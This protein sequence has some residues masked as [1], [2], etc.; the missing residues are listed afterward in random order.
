MGKLLF[1]EIAKNIL[2]PIYYRIP[3]KIRLGKTYRKHRKFLLKTRSW[4]P[5]EIALWQMNKIREIA[6]SAY[7]ETSYYRNALYR[8]GMHPND[9]QTISD[10]KRIPLTTKEII[11]GNIKEF[12]SKK[13]GR[14]QLSYINTAGSTGV[15][16]G[17]YYLKG[18]S[19]SIEWAFVHDI[20]S[21]FGFKMNK[22][23]AILRG[24]VID[25]GLFTRRGLELIMSSY[26]LTEN[27]MKRYIEEINKFRPDYVQAYPSSISLLCQF[28]KE[29]SIASFPSLRMVMCSSENLLSFQKELIYEVLKA[30]I[31]NLYG[32]VEHTSIASNCKFGDY[33]HFYPEYGYVEFIN[34]KGE[35]CEIEGETGEIIATSFTNPAFPL[36]RYKTGDIVTYTKELCRCGWNYKLV[37]EIQGREQEFII[38]KTGRKICIAAINM[39]SD[40]FDNIHQFQFYQDSRG[41]VTFRFIPKEIFSYSDER[42]IRSELNKKLGND[43]ELVLKRVEKIGLSPRGKYKFLIQKLNT[44]F[45]NS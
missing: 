10:F 26:H 3:D 22:K 24:Y 44:D 8:I 31:C 2:Q 11:Q 6:R 38:T 13:Y 40:I 34:D 7:E 27:N 4:T 15:P 25:K 5:A 28:M 43:I 21:R 33:L 29:H 1:I 17:L 16:L 23:H 20:W 32:N 19:T 41:I 39:H 42:N 14:K 36:I 35:E 9:L 18:F 37:K 45:R 30:P 12:I